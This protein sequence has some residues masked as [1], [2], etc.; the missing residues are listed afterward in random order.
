VGGNVDE[1]IGPITLNL[2]ETPDV[3]GGR[4][5]EPNVKRG[6]VVGVG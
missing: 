6:K 3:P 5:D 2:Y 4:Y 1:G